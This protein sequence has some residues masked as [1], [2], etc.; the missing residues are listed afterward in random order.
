MKL[1]HIVITGAGFYERLIYSYLAYR[2]GKGQ[3]TTHYKIYTKWGLS[4]NTVKPV[5]KRLVQM[6][7]LSVE[8][9]AITANEP[10]AQQNK[11]RTDQETF[12]HWVESLSYNLIHINRDD[13]KGSAIRSLWE[14]WQFQG[15]RS[16]RRIARYLGVSPVT[17]QKHIKRTDSDCPTTETKK[18][19]KET[20][21]KLPKPNNQ[22]FTIM[23]PSEVSERTNYTVQVGQAEAWIEKV[24]M[25]LVPLAAA[26]GIPATVLIDG[27][28]NDVLD[29]NYAQ[30]DDFK[31]RCERVISKLIADAKRA[32]VSV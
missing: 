18:P 9:T 26:G 15:R 1:K 4:K 11:R 2:T 27:F 6:G 7:L 5:V 20:K 8:K 10:T 16:I 23:T 22:K 19:K 31:L 17:V 32:G 25:I 14:R 21:P 28:W 29:R 30:R 13:P 3:T 24:R 12:T